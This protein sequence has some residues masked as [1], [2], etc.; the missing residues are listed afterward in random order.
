[1]R[2]YNGEEFNSKEFIDFC[3]KHG[4]KRKFFVAR[5]PQQNGVAERRN[6]IVQEMAQIMLMDSK[7]KDVFWAHVVHTKFHIQNKLMLRNN[8]D[9]T[10]YKLWKGRPVNVK[11]FIAFGSK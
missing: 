8:S 3:N 9:K 5:T 4:I 11:N 7:F 1:L 10:P 2:Y 6:M